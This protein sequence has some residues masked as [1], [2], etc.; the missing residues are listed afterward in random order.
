M[1]LADEEI[2]HLVAMAK[3]E[4]EK[5][6]EN[7]IAEERKYYEPALAKQL[8]IVDSLQNDIANITNNK[9]EVFVF[10]VITG[11]IGIIIGIFLV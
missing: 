11:L 7:A 3:I 8:A 1:T 5:A 10:S 2:G 6:V 9:S 4:K